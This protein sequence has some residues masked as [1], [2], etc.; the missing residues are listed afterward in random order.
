MYWLGSPWV[1]SG[2][3]QTFDPD[4]Q[5]RVGTAMGFGG[6][7]SGR[8]GSG[9]N[10][11]TL[12]NTIAVVVVYHA[13]PCID[14]LPS[15]SARIR[16]PD[17][18]LCLPNTLSELTMTTA[19]KPHYSGQHHDL[20]NVPSASPHRVTITDE[21]RR[22]IGSSGCS[23]PPIDTIAAPSATR[24]PSSYTLESPSSS[25]DSV[26]VVSPPFISSDAT[27]RP[28]PYVKSK[29]APQRKSVSPVPEQKI[30]TITAYIDVAA[31]VLPLTGIKRTA[32]KKPK[33]TKPQLTRHAPITIRVGET[34]Q[35]ILADIA[36]VLKVK[37]DDIDEDR[38]QWKWEVPA[39]SKG[40][41]FA[42]VI[43]MKALMAEIEG[44]KKTS[45][46]IEMDKPVAV[47]NRSEGLDIYGE[48]PEA[49]KVRLE[50]ERST[51][52]LQLAE[53]YPV[54]HC[55]QHPEI[56]CYEHPDSGLHFDLGG[57]TA[58]RKY[59][60]NAIIANKATLQLSPTSSFF[61]ADQ[62]I[63]PK[64]GQAATMTPTAPSHTVPPPAPPAPGQYPPYPPY[65]YAFYPPPN[66]PNYPMPD[67]ANADVRSSSPGP[68]LDS[69]E[70]WAAAVG[71]D[72][73]QVEKLRDLGY[74][75]GE[76]QSLSQVPP[77]EWK[78]VGFKY[79]EWNK[80]LKLV[81]AYKKGSNTM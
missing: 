65:P 25:D 62:A 18:T 38:L 54:G 76:R 12:P 39:N 57:N 64:R 1:G 41:P 30:K 4:P 50:E 71:L 2:F 73:G 40:K 20:H 6:S 48:E 56:S 58:R 32:A 55:K 61:A 3:A 75:P 26:T 51:I 77:E 10:D 79:F 45:L 9:P 27:F 28:V 34:L 52:S 31:P 63:K 67:S 36:S 16:F 42:N 35:E 23:A 80:V 49:K 59:W 8:V 44:T 7:G 13:R 68:T 19:A 29:R 47:G 72:D 74:E 11:P 17:C 5:P 78:A 43:G 81:K 66:Y 22:A 37:V 60:A 21:M 46:I 69:L 14:T 24:L 15:D 70:E 53:L 33:A